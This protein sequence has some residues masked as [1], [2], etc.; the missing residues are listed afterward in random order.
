[1]TGFSTNSIINCQRRTA[2]SKLGLDLGE[3]LMPYSSNS[4]MGELI[5]KLCS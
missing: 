4:G 5:E 2:G 3:A 1:M